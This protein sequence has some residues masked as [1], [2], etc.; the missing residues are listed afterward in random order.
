MAGSVSKEESESRW[1]SFWWQQAGW[2]G[3]SAM[4]ADDGD[5][6][7]RHARKR[8]RK[9][10]REEG[11]AAKTGGRLPPIASEPVRQCRR[12]RSQGEVGVAG[13]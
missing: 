3:V 8:Q 12:G 11:S 1:Y 2:E 9:E 5:P 13:R 6:K 7:Q 10:E 4:R